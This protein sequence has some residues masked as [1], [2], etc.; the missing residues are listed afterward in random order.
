MSFAS[1]FV[2]PDA[3]ERVAKRAGYDPLTRSEKLVL[4]AGRRLTL[5]AGLVFA[6]ML[7]R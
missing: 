2:S 6:W 1:D 3:T 4:P 5:T 7:R